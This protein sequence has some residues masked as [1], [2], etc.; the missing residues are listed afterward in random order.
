[1]VAAGEKGSIIT[2]FAVTA[3][4]VPVVLANPV[5]EAIAP[6]ELVELASPEA[7]SAAPPP[8]NTRTSVDAET[9]A[10]HGAGT[11]LRVRRL[12]TPPP[13]PPT[14][15]PAGRIGGVVQL[16]EGAIV[17]LCTRP[18]AAAAPAFNPIAGTLDAIPA[19]RV[20]VSKPTVVV[21]ANLASS[22]AGTEG[23][24]GAG[25]PTSERCHSTTLPTPPTT[26][27]EG[28]VGGVV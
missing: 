9:Q 26:A 10:A 18:R 16:Q 6:V 5:E 14:A 25:L 11:V 17:P 27:R 24:H 22:E 1:M 23:T 15:T 2:S 13:V 4:A 12:H 28:R 8:L 19:T 20:T 3:A 7:G 21:T